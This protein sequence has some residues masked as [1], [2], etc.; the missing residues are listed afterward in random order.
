MK[1]HS[2]LTFV[3]VAL[4]SAAQSLSSQ[5]LVD[6]EKYPDYNPNV[7]PIEE[8]RAVRSRAGEELPDYVHNGLNKYFPPVFNQAGGSCG[9][10]SRI[11]YMF[12]YEMNAMRDADGS[13]P[14]NQYPSHFTWLLTNNGSGKEGM[15]AATGIPNSVVYGGTTF[16]YTFGDQDCAHSDYGWMQGY[17]K[18]DSA[19][20]NRIERNGNFPVSVE[21]EEGRLAVKRWLYNHNGDTRFHAGGICG[22]GVA[23]GGDFPELPKG[24]P[25]DAI[26]NDLAVKHYV[27][28]WGEQVDHALT[29]VGYDDRVVFDL[30]NDGVYGEADADEIGAWIVV[31]SWGPW[32]CSNGFVYCPYKLATPSSGS[33]GYYCPEVYYA[34]HNYRP[35]RT[36]K[37]KMEYSHRSELKLSAGI[38]S[39]TSATEPEAILEFEHFKYAGD[40]Q[41]S[42][43]A[44]A[45]P[46]LGKWNGKLNYDP[47]EFGYDLTD[48]SSTFNTRKPLKYFFIIE[49]KSNAVGTGKIHSCALMDYEFDK[50]GV[51]N[52]FNL[53]AEGVQVKNAGNKTIIS[54][55]VPGEP[56]NAP[57]NLTLSGSTLKWQEPA[58][59][60]YVRTGFNIYNNGEFLT[61]LAAD[62]FTYNVSEKGNYQVAAVY[63]IGDEEFTSAKTD[64]PMGEFEGNRPT[65][66]NNHTFNS[67]GITIKHIVPEHLP[68]ATIEYWSKPSSLTNWNQQIGPGW[69][70][71]L[72]HTTNKGEFVYGWSNANR[73]TSAEGTLQNGVWQ[74]MAIVIDG[75]KMRG[76]KNGKLLGEVAGPN[77]IGG[78]G[79]LVF[80][81]NNSPMSGG[82]DEVRIWKTARTEQQINAMM[83][84]EIA[85]PLNT[86]GLLCELRMDESTGA[87]LT[88]E[89]GKHQIVMNGNST[90]SIDLN[91]FK[92]TQSLTS[93]FSFPDGPYYVGQ[94]IKMTNKSS[95]FATKFAWVNSENDKDTLNV[96]EPTYIFSSPGAKTIKLTAY[97]PDASK[98]KT[99]TIVIEAVPS[100]VASF[101]IPASALVGD[102]VSFINTT[103]PLDGCSYEWSM[104]GAEVEAALT[105]NAA[106]SYST[107]GE[108]TVT[109]TARNSFG[110]ESTI[111]KKIIISNSAPEPEFEVRPMV[112]LKGDE[113]QLVDKSI[114]SPQEWKWVI[115]DAAHHFEYTEQNP[116]ASIVNPGIYDV[117]LTAGNALGSNSIEK[118]GVITVSNADSRSGLSFNN[119]S[120]EKVTFN[121]PV[122]LT[123]N[124]GFT[125]D[126]WMS[127]K[128]NS[129]VS[130][131]I[132]GTSADF[133][134]ITDTEGA[135]RFYMCNQQLA[136][137]KG[138]VTI[139]GWHHYAAVVYSAI[140]PLYNLSV[141]YVEVYRDGKHITTLRIGGTLPRMPEKFTLG[142]SEGP[143]NAVIDELRI[144]NKVMTL[145]EIMQY[146]NQPIEDVQAAV[147]DHNL[148]LYYDF[149]DGTGNVSDLVGNNDGIRT[150]FGPD[151]DAWTSSLGAFCL[152]TSEGQDVS[153]TY[154][155][156]YQA[157]FIT[158]TA[159]FN[160]EYPQYIAVKRGVGSSMWNYSGEVKNGDVTTGVCVDTKHDSTLVIVTKQ[161]GFSGE[162]ND[163]K[164]YQSVK[165][166]LPAGHYVFGVNVDETVTGMNDYIVVAP[167]QA[168]PSTDNL[169]S[170]LGFAPIT[171]GEVSFS[172]EKDTQVR[173]G[174][175]LNTRGETKQHFRSFYLKRK[176]GLGDMTSID[177]PVADGT[178]SVE[179]VA[180]G[181]MVNAASA[182]NVKVYSVD[183]KLI[184]D[185]VVSGT[186]Y[187]ALPAGVYVVNKTKVVV[188]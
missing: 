43:N 128:G 157:P 74:H 65:L 45:V 108:Y 160:P 155:T 83:S 51:E 71:F 63:G 23:S 77:G 143:M 94:E 185:N 144:W 140:D 42:Q 68:Q 91:V 176:Y 178:T 133:K 10:A 107:P 181:V 102:R 26:W 27:R 35:L 66:I 28:S 109:L 171:E 116:S 33:N 101:E 180:G 179:A 5:V 34:R 129:S 147:A 59:T 186:E 100:P 6:Y 164:F 25:N 54:V 110:E 4:L 14:E 139:S 151:G 16:S 7:K 121:C 76:Y 159:Q 146:A 31:N 172:I 29:I 167:T 62:V 92:K 41:N 15:A 104:P 32:W 36:F 115:S 88:D 56:L 134:I 182:T 60:N 161:E 114:N 49:S 58:S 75:T 64:S 98:T 119:N 3:M 125:I 127:V 123:K 130:H 163:H 162:V 173:V 103:T 87:T 50:D 142:G 81:S 188:G 153:S 22:I 37:I 184:Y 12:A 89:T 154:L 73:V 1:N 53:G 13:L 47:M 96:Y 30:D 111:S 149:N 2:L 166:K 9:S 52:A 20:F 113:V 105:T 57:R 61:R 131:C 70:H 152:S 170:A 97:T 86:P 40:G 137:E 132:G 124:N 112:I 118:R 21:S 183:G 138:V 46:M 145:E 90:Q 24:T 67:S 187:I 175:L 84:Y 69:G 85:D 174:L 99:K 106:A 80:G 19:M 95:A 11:S 44:P 48:F 135:L 55:V 39:D 120:S 136:T 82:I 168:F 78:F 158:G 122:D 165:T 156:N 177:T 38:A 17:D 117:K 169:S 72:S 148:A 18:W 141:K 79:D 126:W 93:N 8:L 150:G